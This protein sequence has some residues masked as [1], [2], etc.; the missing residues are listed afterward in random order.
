MSIEASQ[1][2]DVR[3]F[4]LPPAFFSSSFSFFCP[5]RREAAV[6]RVQHLS[7]PLFFAL[8]RPA[9]N[10]IHLSLAICI[11]D[12]SP[13]SFGSPFSMRGLTPINSAEPSRQEM[14]TLPRLPLLSFDTRVDFS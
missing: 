3:G 12:D 10:G 4:P 9:P 11:Y 7:D 5:P 6:L 1:G 8:R 2:L 13:S 14:T